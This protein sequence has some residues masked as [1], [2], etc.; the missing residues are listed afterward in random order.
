MSADRLQQAEDSLKHRYD[1]YVGVFDSGVGGISVLKELVKEV[2]DENY[3]FFGDSLHAPYGEKTPGEIRKL[4]MKG[5][6]R[7]AE[8]GVKA[9]VIAC[10]TATSAAAAEVRQKYQP[11]LPVIGIEPAIKPAAEACP[12]GKISSEL[13]R[14]R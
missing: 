7:L 4:T 8:A 10:N 9:I 6:D 1:G 12:H 13:P 2:P 14:R 3:L 11:H 5:I